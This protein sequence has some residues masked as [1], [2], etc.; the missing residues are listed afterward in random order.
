MSLKQG[1]DRE[2]FVFYKFLNKLVKFFKILCGIYTVD[3]IY[4]NEESLT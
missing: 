2:N 1:N 3:L 4:I